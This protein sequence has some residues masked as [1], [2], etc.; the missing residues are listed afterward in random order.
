VIKIKFRMSAEFAVDEVIEGKGNY[1]GYAKAVVSDADG[2]KFK[3]GIKGERDQWLADLL[4][5][6]HK[7]ATVEFFS[8]TKGGSGV[9]APGR[10]HQV[11]WRQARPLGDHHG[12]SDRLPKRRA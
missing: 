1:A 8:Y 6:G 3:A 9:P 12:T 2:R 7:I 4:T 5:A 10:R 11:A